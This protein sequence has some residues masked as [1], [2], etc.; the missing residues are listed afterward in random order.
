MKK[1]V[2][3]IVSILLSNALVF[4]QDAAV[5]DAIQNFKNT[6]FML[7]YMDLKREIELE[8][9]DF[10][11]NQNKYSLK[12]RRRVQLS[13]DRTA[14]RFNQVLVD[15]KQDFLDKEKIKM[16]NKYPKMYSDGL[17]NKVNDLDKFYK[18]NFQLV[19][20]EVTEKNGFA[21]LALIME[22]IKSSGELSGYFKGL[23]F[24]KKAMSETYIQK[25]LIEPSKLTSW[26]ELTQKTTV[27]PESELPQKQTEPKSDQPQTETSTEQ[28]KGD[29]K[30]EQTEKQ[31][32]PKTTDKE[33]DD[34]N[35]TRSDTQTAEPSNTTPTDTNPNPTDGQGDKKVEVDESSTVENPQSLK[36]VKPVK[37]Q[38]PKKKKD[39]Q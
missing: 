19:F 31:A 29:T 6:E 28:P 16:I 17:S 12:D 1:L 35:N 30:T 36:A 26:A 22:L 8:A 23:K 3:L 32:E 34:K 4:S 10:I 5:G 33:T 24:E 13:Y 20:T 14:A 18:E 39:E 38:L 15:I 27:I 7:K 11:A 37:K 2:I 25:N 9:Q 21:I